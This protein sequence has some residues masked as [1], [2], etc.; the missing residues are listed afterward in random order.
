MYQISCDARLQER[1]GTGILPFSPLYA[2]L[3]LCLHV[4]TFALLTVGTAQSRLQSVFVSERPI[5][6]RGF[7]FVLFSQHCYCNPKLS[8]CCT[9]CISLP[10]VSTYFLAPTFFQPRH[11][12]LVTQ[13]CRCVCF[14]QERAQEGARPFLYLLLTQLQAPAPP[15]LAVEN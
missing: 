13:E 5:F 10:P 8:W 4:T 3:P 7:I 6:L 1:V 11:V 14:E 12:L 9:F 15:R 2:Q